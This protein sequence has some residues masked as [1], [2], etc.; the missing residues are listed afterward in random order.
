M[1]TIKSLFCISVFALAMASCAVQR[2]FVEVYRQTKYFGLDAMPD[3][4][5]LNTFSKTYYED[6]TGSGVSIGGKYEISRD[7]LRLT[8]KY[9]VVGGE[10]SKEFDKNSETTGRSMWALLIKGRDLICLTPTGEYSV[11]VFRRLKT[12]R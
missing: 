10:I 4:I 3:Y 6:L 12:R 1:R 9:E 7:T 2:E 11:I 5:T 8:P